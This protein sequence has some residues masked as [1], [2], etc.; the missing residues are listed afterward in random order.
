MKDVE[1][2]AFDWI[3]GNIYFNDY[4]KKWIMAVDSNFQYY[5]VIYRNIS[6]S[7]YGLALHSKQR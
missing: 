1:Q 6:E 5:T 4:K 7:F 3:T 2:I